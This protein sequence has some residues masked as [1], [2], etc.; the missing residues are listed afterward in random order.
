DWRFRFRQVPGDPEQEQNIAWR[1]GT[2]LLLSGGLDSLAAAVELSQGSGTSVQ[3]V[4]HTTRNRIARDAQRG[5]VDLLTAA[6]YNMPLYQLFVSSQKG[7][8]NP[9]HDQENSQRT[10]SFLFLILAALAARR[11]AHG[12]LVWLAE[13]G[14]MAIHL[15]LVPARVGAFSTHTANPEF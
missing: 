6:G 11:R 8:R 2:T 5:I 7:T 12:R 4:S 14:H 15:P 1:D 3:L 13:N 9:D 10:R